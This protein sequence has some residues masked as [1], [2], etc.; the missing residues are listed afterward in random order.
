M[1]HALAMAGPEIDREVLC[2]AVCWHD[3]DKLK[4][5]ELK[6]DVTLGYKGTIGYTGYIHTIGHVAG[7]AIAFSFHAGSIPAL[8]KREK[9]IHCILSHHGRKEWGS[10]VEPATRE[11]WILHASDMLSSRE[12]L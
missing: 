2:T 9:I 7:S 11:A 12:A 3:Y 8:L 10:P 1:E 6:D 4:E 5:Y